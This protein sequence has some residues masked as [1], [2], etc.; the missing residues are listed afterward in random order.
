MNPTQ[1]A[2]NYALLRFLP[3]PETG[4]FVNVGVLVSCQQPCSLWFVAERTMPE[5]AKALF[6]KQNV[7]VFEA[8]LE[9]LRQEMERVKSGA[10]D[11]KSV[12]H[13]FNESVR[14]RESVFRFGEVR[15]IL[16]ANP[17]TLAEELFS[18]YVRMEIPA[19]HGVQSASA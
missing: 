2:C 3:Y 9:A 18:R 4:E 5:R 13:A 17:Q 6:P 1:Q 16:T 8:S 10:R 12:Q 15:T 19:M 14:I 7:Q 11:P